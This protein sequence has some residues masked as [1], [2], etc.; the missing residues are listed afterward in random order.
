M[1]ELPKATGRVDRR[2]QE[3]RAQVLEAAEELFVERGVEATKIDDICAAADVAKR[4]VS[5]FLRGTR[6]TGCRRR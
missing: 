5:N 1:P 6:N 4:T 3:F 2:V